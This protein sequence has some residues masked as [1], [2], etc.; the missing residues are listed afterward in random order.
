MQGSVR[1]QLNNLYGDG[2]FFGPL[3][4]ST[5]IGSI[6]ASTVLDSGHGS[7]NQTKAPLLR[8]PSFRRPDSSEQLNVVSKVSWQSAANMLE[9]RRVTVSGSQ[10]KEPLG[11]PC[12]VISGFTKVVDQFVSNDYNME[13]SSSCF[14]GPSTSGKNN[15]VS[16]SQESTPASRVPE[17]GARSVSE[18][19]EI[20]ADHGV[21]V[22][23]LTTTTTTKR[24]RSKAPKHSN[25]VESQRMTHIAVERNRRKQMNEHLA[26]LRA[27]MPGSYVQKVMIITEKEF[28]LQFNTNCTSHPWSI[29]TSCM[30]E[31]NITCMR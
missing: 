25:E 29:K 28:Y 23:P 2:N 3:N 26:A 7:K 12:S 21:V 5:Q 19:Q 1:D 31:T 14:N 22:K 8:Q 6:A 16:R 11:S 9:P 27:L 10:F 13:I 30:L 18:T 15:N 24:K 17:G 4:S 20:V